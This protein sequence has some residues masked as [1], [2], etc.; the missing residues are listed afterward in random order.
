VSFSRTRIAGI[1]NV[2]AG[3][4][5]LGIY[6]VETIRKLV[7]EGSWPHLETL[8]LTLPGPELFDGLCDGDL[9]ILLD[10]CS[11]GEVAGTVHCFDTDEIG[12]PGLRHLSTHGLGLAE[13]I[14]L[15]QAAGE[16]TPEVRVYSI[17]MQHC[18]MGEPL[19]AAVA[20]SMPELLKLI[21]S[22]IDSYQT[23][24]CYA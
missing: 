24:E 15:A 18:R 2:L 12:Y 22:C 11:S 8:A 20:A 9:L 3:D 6:A 14:S 10:A 21:R 5:G 13:W 19:S 7:S 23:G 1:G 4:D 16:E 17:E